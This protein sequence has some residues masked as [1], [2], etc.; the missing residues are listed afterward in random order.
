MRPQPRVR[1]LASLPNMCAINHT[2]VAH[3][4]CV[5]WIMYSVTISNHWITYLTW[6][7][8]TCAM[9][10]SFVAQWMCSGEHTHIHFYT[11]AHMATSMYQTWCLRFIQYV[12]SVYA[13]KHPGRQNSGDNDAAESSPFLGKGLPSDTWAEKATLAQQ[14]EQIH[15]ASSFF[16]SF[17]L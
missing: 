3:I 10:F 6:I 8:H 1:Y 16:H 13:R 2:H 4:I 15:T 9:T 17:C 11:H 12:A 5:P 14:N 7:M